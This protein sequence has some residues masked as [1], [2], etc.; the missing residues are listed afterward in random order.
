MRVRKYKH[1]TPI[2]QLHWLPISTWIEYKVFLHTHQC[3]HGNVPIYLKEL[4]APQ[5]SAR[6][7][8]SKNT[9][10]LLP[11]RTKTRSI[12]DRA[13]YTTAPRLWHDLPEHLRA[14]QLTDG[15]KTYLFKK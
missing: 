12:G 8:H 2:L 15:L 13:F 9:Y 3:I 14:P 7:L 11:H 6:S 1:I 4:L 10:C 5:I